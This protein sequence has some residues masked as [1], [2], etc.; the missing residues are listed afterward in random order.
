MARALDAALGADG[1]LADLVLLAANP[2]DLDR[3]A[4]ATA[5]PR[6]IGFATIE[7]LARVLAAKRNLDD[8][9]GSA[10]VV[11]STVAQLHTLTVIVNEAAGPDRPAV[12]YEAGQWAQFAAWLHISVG[13]QTEARAWLARALQWSMECG[14]ADL[15]ATVLSYQAH[16]EWLSLRWGPTV[17]LAQAALRDPAVYP[18]QRAYD[19]YQAARGSAALGDLDEA[20]RMLDRADGYAADTES[21]D[22][23]PPP[24]QYYRAPWFWALERGLVSLY[25]ARRE[26][27]YASA[28]VADLQAGI[29]GLPDEMSGADWVAEYLV[30][31]ASAHRRTGERDAARSTLGRAKFIADATHSGRVLQLVAVGERSL[32]VNGD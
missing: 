29:D 17:G 13:K 6:R 15:I 14:D 31:L 26:P 32:R 22:G 27:A 16:S 18:G 8:V 2:E 30:H 1:Q 28:A 11:G 25:M 3:L 9:M 23:Q 20:R 21:W 24:W 12:L 7:S 4:A 5:N 10:A 19:A